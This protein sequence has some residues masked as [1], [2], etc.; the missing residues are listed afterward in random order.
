MLRSV[1]RTTAFMGKELT[2][3]LRR[4]GTVFSLILGPFAI[5]ALFGFGYVGRHDFDAVVVVP[6]GSGMPV[7]RAFYQELA[8]GNLVVVAVVPD[9]EEGRDLLL[10]QRVDLLIAAPADAR[11]ELMEG[12]QSV[13]Q[14]E[15]DEL[16]PMIAGLAS[17]VADRL[18]SKLNAE[19]IERLAGEGIELARSAATEERLQVSPEVVASPVRTQTRN[20]APTSPRVVDFYGPAVFALILQHVAVTLAALTMVRERLGGMM[21]L[22]RVSPVSSTELL[23]GKYLAFGLLSLVVSAAVAALT[24]AVLGVPLLGGWMA[25]SVVA[26]ALTF[27]ALGLGLLISLVADSERQAV[28]LSMLVLLASVFLSGFVLPVD[29]FHAPVRAIS[30]ALPVTHATALLQSSMLRGTLAPLWSFAALLVIGIVLFGLARARLRR[31]MRG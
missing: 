26:A 11:T 1:I 19:I 5:M 2:E 24:V 28:Q 16:D 31:V 25:F 21:E 6:E 8:G 7:E 10:R 18:V 9:V 17:V 12:R 3:L 22:F 13:V 30:Y 27:G 15:W 29:D 20:W 14:V 23:V 4:P